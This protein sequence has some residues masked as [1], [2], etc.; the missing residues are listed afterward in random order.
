MLGS[1]FDI[2]LFSYISSISN[3]LKNLWLI[4]I[5]ASIL[6]LGSNYNNSKISSFPSGN[7]SHSFPTNEK[8]PFKI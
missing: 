5:P 1:L 4:A 7:N 2:S 3:L 8:S 6:S